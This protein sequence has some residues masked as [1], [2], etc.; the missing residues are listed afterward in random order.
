MRDRAL[1]SLVILIAAGTVLSG[2]VAWALVSGVRLGSARAEARAEEARL[3]RTHALMA[4]APFRAQLAAALEA[5]RLDAVPFRSKLKGLADRLGITVE[6]LSQT[7]TQ[8]P[9]LSQ[10]E[11]TV[12]L[13]LKDVSMARFLD[14]ARTVEL[15]IPDAVV[16]QAA[17]KPVEHAG[18]RWEAQLKI[19]RRVKLDA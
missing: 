17:L 5:Q 11:I 7:E 15:E 4:D 14:Y 1:P 8:L 6:G 9:I 19:S 3:M 10:K 12:S 2:A 13:T 18:D 16:S